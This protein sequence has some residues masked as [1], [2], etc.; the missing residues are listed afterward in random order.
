MA[1]NA[2]DDDICIKM[3]SRINTVILYQ[4][5]IYYILIHLYKTLYYFNSNLTSKAIATYYIRKLELQI[6]YNLK[7][8]TIKLS[9]IHWFLWQN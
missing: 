5:Y 4:Y 9:H 2:N 3:Y 1:D 6:T 7:V 8:S